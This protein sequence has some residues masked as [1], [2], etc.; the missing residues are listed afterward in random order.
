GYNAKAIDIW[1]EGVRF[2]AVK[3]FDR[4]RER[5]DILYMAKVNNRTPGFIGDLRSQIG[6]AQLG[7][8]RLKEIIDRFGLPAVK[9]AVD[10]SIEH[11]ARR[12]KQEVLAWPDGIYEADAFVDHDP[13]GNK[14]IRV[15]VK[16]TV[17]GEH[18]TIDFG[19][20]DMRQDLKAYSSFGNTRG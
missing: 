16:I 5:K 13:A 7:V 4:G 10:H 14:D 8:R 1:A 15:H 20:T 9:D 19:G 11:A 6:A 12:F 2:P 17:E 3:L 18:L